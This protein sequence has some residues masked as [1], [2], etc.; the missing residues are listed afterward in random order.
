M[1]KQVSIKEI[2]GIGEKTAQAFAKLGI[3]SIQ[4]LLLKYPRTYVCYPKVIQ[5]PVQQPFEEGMYAI[6]AYVQKAPVLKKTSKMVIAN[7]KI[8]S[9]SQQLELI[10]FRMPYIQKTVLPRKKFVFY[11]KIQKWQSIKPEGWWY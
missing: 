3:Y 5:L 8:Q 7:L 4:D 1:Q 10:W 6:G 9:Q 2:K 11:G